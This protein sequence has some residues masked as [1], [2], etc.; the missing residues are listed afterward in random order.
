MKDL[1]VLVP[2]R[3]RPENGHA[4]LE[5]FEQTG[6]VADLFFVLDAGDPTARD[7]PAPAEGRFRLTVEGRGMVAALNRAAG[8]V[9]GFARAVAFLGDDHRPRTPAWDGRLLD[10][11]DRLGTGIVYGN[12]LLQGEQMPTAVAMTSDIVQALGYMAPPSLQHLNV[13]VVWREWGKA[14]DRLVY[15]DDVVIEH[16]HPAVGKAPLDAGYERVNSVDM[17]ARDG[18]AFAAYMADDFATDVDKLRALL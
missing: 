4:L 1:A 14:I 6:T 11:L 12:D 17:V 10:E 5:A 13:D 18:E 15:L 2:S 8:Y 9:S 16:L 3:G 7:Y